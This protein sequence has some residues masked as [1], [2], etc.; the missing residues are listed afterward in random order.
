MRPAT[1]DVEIRFILP[2]SGA[3]VTQHSVVTYPHTAYFPD[4]T[5]EGTA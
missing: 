2:V 1:L 5:P 4:L 3:D